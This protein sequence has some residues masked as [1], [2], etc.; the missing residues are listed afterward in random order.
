MWRLFKSELNYN[1]SLIY[2]LLSLLPAVM[3]A[4]SMINFDNSWMIFWVILLILENWVIKRNNERREYFFTL[5]PIPSWQKGF[6]RIFFIVIVC[7]A[8]L[9]IFQLLLFLTN[10]GKVLE[11]KYLIVIYFLVLNSFSIYF[12]IRDSLLYFMRTNPYL[13]ISRARTRIVLKLSLFAFLIAGV[14]TLLMRSQLLI[15]F[16]DFL[17]R[18]N[19][20]AGAFGI[21]KFCTFSLIMA[22]LSVYSYQKR[23]ASLE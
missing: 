6:L 7:G 4:T 1:K 17:I 22:A 14:I 11:W 18:I 8:F 3:I 15:D 23:K 16:I 21:I 12:I 9:P 19:P 20:F 10:K 2:F 5:L 13:K